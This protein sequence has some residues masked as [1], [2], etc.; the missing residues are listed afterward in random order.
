MATRSYNGQEYQSATTSMKW[1]TPDGFDWTWQTWEDAKR[2]VG[3]AKKVTNRADGTVD[4][5]TA[6]AVKTE[7][8]MKVRKSEWDRFV[9][10]V[11]AFYPDAEIDTI[12]FNETVA[13]GNS[14]QVIRKDTSELL[15]QEVNRDLPKSQDALMVD[16]PLCL[17]AF[18]ENGKPRFQSA[19]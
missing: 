9:D 17:V 5:W 14:L 15:L 2:K 1:S 19:M 11:A 12:L 7:A 3:R 16:V 13:Y 8:G 10:A 6:E 4:G 18:N